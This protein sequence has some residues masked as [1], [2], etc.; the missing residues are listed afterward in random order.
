MQVVVIGANACGA[1]SACRVKRLNPKAEVILIDKDDLISYGACGIPY[2]VSGDVPHENALR[3]TSYHVVRDEKFFRDAKGLKVLTKTLVEEIDRKRKT[4]RVRYLNTGQI[5][6][7]PYDKLIIATGSIPRTLNIPGIDLQG[8]YTLTSLH[9]AIEIKEKIARGEVEKPLVIGAGLIGLEMTEAFADLWELPVTL[10]EYFPQVLPRNLD[11]FT[12]RMVE[13]H[14]REK[15]V[16]LVLNARI[17]EI[18]G[19]DGK[20]IGV[21]TENEFY[22]ADLVLVAGG[23]IPNSELAK[24]AGLLVS[25]ATGGIVV[26]DRLQ[27]SDPDIYAGGDCIEVTHLITGKKVVMP[28]GSLANRQGRVIGTNIAGGTATFKGTVGAFIMK[29]FD[30]AVG[31]VGLTLTQA[32]IEG[33]SASYALNNQTERSHFFPDAKYA[34]YALIF[35]KLTTRV[36]GFQAI[37]PFT[38]GTLARIHALSSILPYKPLVEDLLNLELAYAP[39]F[40]SALDPIHDTAHVAD[41]ILKG[42][43]EPIHWEEVIKR[44]QEG[45]QNTLIIDLRHPKEA[46]FNVKNFSNVKHILYQKI[47]YHI[48]EIPKDK[49]IIL[50]CNSSRRSYE[51]AR[52]LKSEGY[53]RVYVPL[54]GISFPRKWGEPVK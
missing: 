25:P 31:G 38:D 19:K 41:N 12:A 21:Q 8:V 48:K 13:N 24:K 54:G 7:I 33:F 9:K 20:V 30:L 27:T 53:E 45:D 34:Y 14:L 23:V 52:I 1:K 40:N 11:A 22:P 42:L 50:I 44:M 2:F 3:E 17:K 43:F 26:N 16:K 29:C 35:D 6:E 10:L 4:I 37:G 28:M 15:G 47:R 32:K 36:L 5:E 18:M 39:P 51:V 49:D 46:E